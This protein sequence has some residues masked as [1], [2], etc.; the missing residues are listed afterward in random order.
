MR[1]DRAQDG[2]NIVRCDVQGKWIE[3][4]AGRHTNIRL[5]R[6]GYKRMEENM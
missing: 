4:A 1:L 2:I 6:V 5:G 3:L